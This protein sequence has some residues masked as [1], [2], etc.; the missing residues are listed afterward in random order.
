M[1]Q[2]QTKRTAWIRD[3][4]FEAECTKLGLEGWELVSVQHQ[5]RDTRGYFK[6]TAP[7]PASPAKELLEGTCDPHEPGG[8]R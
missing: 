4:A 2:W 8:G 7:S 5:E 6:R 1:Q 3:D